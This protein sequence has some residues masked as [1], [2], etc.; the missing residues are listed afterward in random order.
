MTVANWRQWSQKTRQSIRTRATA[1]RHRL[2][3]TIR[4]WFRLP[5]DDLKEQRAK[6]EQDA[7]QAIVQQQAEAINGM[8]RILN[9]LHQRLSTYEAEIPRMRELKRGLE[10]EKVG[11]RAKKTNGDL[12]IHP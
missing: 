3:L 6:L 7:L 10:L 4:W 9:D 11:I 12:I 1:L 2:I 5:I 8:I